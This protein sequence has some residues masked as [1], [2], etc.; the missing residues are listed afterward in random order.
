MTVKVTSEKHHSSDNVICQQRVLAFIRLVNVCRMT[1]CI[2]ISCHITSVS[3]AVLISA[4]A[5]LKSRLYFWVKGLFPSFLLFTPWWS[6]S[7]LLLRVC[8]III[9]LFQPF[10][11]CIFWWGSLFP[12]SHIRLPSDIKPR[13]SYLWSP[14][15]LHGDLTSPLSLTLCLFSISHLIFPSQLH[16]TSLHSAHAAHCISYSEC[17]LHCCRVSKGQDLHPH[18]GGLFSSH[19][20][21]EVVVLFFKIWI[22]FFRKATAKTR[23]RLIF[24]PVPQTAS[25]YF[26]MA[27]VRQQ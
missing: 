6:K 10:P 14:H 27:S 11:F 19:G 25:H 24:Q 17:I 9:L 8:T 16:L 3:A 5:F 4:A 1:L 13:E 23:T 18:Q 15:P 12:S 22:Q 20:S 21:K 2:M 7:S 26:H